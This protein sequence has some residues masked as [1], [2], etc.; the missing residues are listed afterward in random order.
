MSTKDDRLDQGARST[1]RMKVVFLSFAGGEPRETSRIAEWGQRLRDAGFEVIDH[2][3]WISYDLIMTDIARCD[4]MVAP[5]R[6]NGATWAAIEATS[7]GEGWNTAGRLAPNGPQAWPPK[8]VLFWQVPDLG[9]LP[10]TAMGYT[11]QLLSSG[12][13][14]R[15]PDDFEAAVAQAISLI[16]SIRNDA[17]RV[18][19]DGGGSLN[20]Y[21]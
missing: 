10:F 12:R 20:R 16:G 8:P 5:V 14:E 4:A 15:L 11:S 21:S 9:N 3:R 2:E 18:D 13:A 6:R 17:P 7:A 1:S 19:G